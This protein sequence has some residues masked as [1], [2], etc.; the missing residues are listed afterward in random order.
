MVAG[1]IARRAWRACPR[2]ATR[3]WTSTSTRQHLFTVYGNGGQQDLI[4]HSAALSSRVAATQDALVILASRSHARWLTDTDFMSEFLSSVTNAAED[5]EIH[6]V[7]AAVD[8]LLPQ[9][10]FTKARQGISICRGTVDGLLPGLWTGDAAPTL[11]RGVEGDAALFFNTTS[12]LKGTAP[13]S[14][15]LTCSLPLANTVFQNNRQSTLLAS[16]W[17]RSEN[18]RLLELADMV[19]KQTQ[20]VNYT[21]DGTTPPTAAVHLP[22]GPVT[23]PRVI[24]AGL[25]NIVRQIEVDGTPTPASRELEDAVQVLYD[26]WAARGHPLQG[27]LS[28]WALVIPPGA[29]DEP[30]LSD[31]TAWQKDVASRPDM[32]SEL[33]ATEQ[34]SELVVPLLNKG[35]RVY[36]VLSGGG[37]WG[38]KAGLL[39]LEPD[40]KFAMPGDEEGLDSF[41]RSFAGGDAESHDLDVV[42]PGS[43]IQYYVQP[44]LEE[45]ATQGGDETFKA[46]AVFGTSRWFTEDVASSSS[47]SEWVTMPGL[48]GG[49]SETGLYISDSQAGEDGGLMQT[50]ITV[51]DTFVRV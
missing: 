28:V 9:T 16:R 42:A 40:T 29:V 34:A 35:A 44:L 30:G 27:P 43:V 37:G 1:L 33:Q 5:Q 18:G 25:G 51:P 26:R 3:R 21:G 13:T 8:G 22:F 38:K 46:G 12:H 15:P 24:A 45:Q 11:G 48:F 7:A 50:K 31:L 4:D 19:S 32:A 6:V 47:G 41:M 14:S 20:N 17:R 10:P 2:Q 23:A 36:R 49:V 39:S